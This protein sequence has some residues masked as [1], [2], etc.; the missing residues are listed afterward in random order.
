MTDEPQTPED[1]QAEMAAKGW[2][3]NLSTAA[4]LLNIRNNDP[5]GENI[6]ADLEKIGKRSQE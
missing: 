4:H 5:K 2:T 3:I 6:I 1:M